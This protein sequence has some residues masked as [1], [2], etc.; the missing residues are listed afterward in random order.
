MGMGEAIHFGL[1]HIDVGGSLGKDAVGNVASKY[2]LGIGEE[3]SVYVPLD[4]VPC[5]EMVRA[6]I[7]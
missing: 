2:L 4:Q 1:V 5:M 3:A 6:E 7:F